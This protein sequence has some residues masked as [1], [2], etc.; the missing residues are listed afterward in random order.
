[1][2][3]LDDGLVQLGARVRPEV[4]KELKMLSVQHGSTMQEEVERAKNVT[5]R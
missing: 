1:V 3:T 5:T 4:R 2:A